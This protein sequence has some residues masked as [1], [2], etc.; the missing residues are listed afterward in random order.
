MG[1]CG[2][3]PAPRGRYLPAQ[4]AGESA[5]AATQVSRILPG[6]QPNYEVLISGKFRNKNAAKIATPEQIAWITKFLGFHTNL[7]NVEISEYYNMLCQ[8]YNTAC[9]DMGWKPVT[10][11]TMRLWGIKYGWLVNAGR[12]G[13]KEYMNRYGMQNKRFAPTAPLLFWSLDGWT[14]EL[15]Y[16]KRTEGR[17]GGRTTYCNRM[18]VVVVLDPFNKYPI[19]YATGYQESPELIKAALR[20]ATNHTAELFGQRLRPVVQMQG[21]NYQIKIMLPTYGM[22]EHVTPTGRQ[23]KGQA[24]RAVFQTAQP[25]IR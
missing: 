17:R 10:S 18:T 22:A 24:D 13:A 25:Q 16:K 20:N 7:D 1:C 9:R 5:S 3:A 15:Y 21:D 2:G 4:S 11:E 8:A 12:H 14:V 19:G 23:R 6:G